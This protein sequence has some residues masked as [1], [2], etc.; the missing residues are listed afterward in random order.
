MSTA[1]YNALVG[2]PLTRGRLQPDGAAIGNG[3]TLTTDIIC[4]G[5]STLAIIV[6]MT[7]GASGDLAVEVNPY[8]ADGVT[9]QI[10]Q[11]PPVQTDGPD[12]AGGH[13]YYFG[14]FDVDGIDKVQV[15][16]TNN[17]AAP[18]VI[19]RAGWRLS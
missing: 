10:N 11:L 6:D 3:V 7:A 8:E 2:A 5:D 13:D 4:Q 16:I 17:N 12:L 15:R 9:R 19:T 1:N 18:Q 14:K